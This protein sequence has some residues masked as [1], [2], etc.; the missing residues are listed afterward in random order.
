MQRG[1]RLSAIRPTERTVRCVRAIAAAGIL[2]AC[3]AQTESRAAIVPS[4]ASTSASVQG[5]VNGGPAT[6][7]QADVNQYRVDVFSPPGGPFNLSASPPPG[8][9]TVDGASSTANAMVDATFTLNAVT[10][11]LV[12]SSTGSVTIAL[13]AT[14]SPSSNRFTGAQA[15]AQAG[16]GLEFVIDQSYDYEI[17]GS[18]FDSSA[19]GSSYIIFQ[20]NSNAFHFERFSNGTGVGAST[21]TLEPGTYTIFGG[22]A[23]GGT[24]AIHEGTLSENADYQFTLRVTPS[25]VRWVNAAGGTFGDPLNWVPQRVPEKSA[26]HDDVALFDLPNNY[27]VDINGPRTIERLVVRDGTVDFNNNILTVAATSPT[28]PSVSIANDGRLNI[29]TGGLRS[30]HAIIGNAPPMDPANPPTAEVLVANVNQGWQLTG[31]LAVG[32]AGKGRLFMAN[33]GLVGSASATIGGPFGGEAIVG[34]HASR[35][36]TGN[37]AVG[38]GGNGSLNIEAGGEVESD[39]ANFVGFTAGSVGEVTVTGIDAT[40]GSSSSWTTS[41]LLTIG[42]SG[43]TGGL[44]IFDGGVV[45]TFALAVANASGSVGRVV[46]SGRN[47]GGIFQESRLLTE[48]IVVG[49][50][51]LA[52]MS[53]TNGGAVSCNLFLKI[54]DGGSLDIDGP[55]SLVDVAGDVNV[56]DN[57]SGLIQFNGGRMVVGGLLHVGPGG[58]LAGN[59]TLIAPNRTV[60]IGGNINAGLSPGMLTF[61]ADFVQTA[62]A[63]LHIEVAG[64]AP[65]LFDL[66]EITGDATLGGTLLLEFIDGFAPRQGDEFKFLDVGGALSGAFDG[67]KVRNLLPGFQFDLRPDAGGLTIVA[68]N[69]GVFV[70]EPATFVLFA[71][72]LGSWCLRRGRAD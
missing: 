28:E 40:D 66:V 13:S 72:A 60:E 53:V 56:G 12:V 31:N 22:A 48:A 65:G 46:V 50:G 1:K 42:H 64:T 6:N 69:D 23:D 71:F 26:T 54:D 41:N 30:V 39:L 36:T 47:A 4:N 59:G 61:E 38:S 33:G 43:A 44:N 16:G 2:V 14:S 45:S 15:Y 19:G 67:V 29:A 35:W 27:A 32:G 17:I 51:D 7:P 3:V 63:V 21:G 11:T 10:D 25:G 58:E 52:L 5:R 49:G 57:G 68:L 70:P 55:T 18:V 34:G 24:G 20:D 9:T 37:L 8:T 62:T